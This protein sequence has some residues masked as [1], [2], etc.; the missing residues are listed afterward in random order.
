MR[1]RC[2]R[3]VGPTVGEG[4]YVRTCCGVRRCT[5]RVHR[6]A[7][8]GRNFVLSRCP[9]HLGVGALDGGRVGASSGRCRTLARRRLLP[10]RLDKRGPSNLAGSD[11][12]DDISGKSLLQE[13]PLQ[14]LQLREIPRGGRD[15]GSIH[16]AAGDEPFC[17]GSSCRRVINPQFLQE[18]PRVALRGSEDHA[19]QLWAQCSVG[20]R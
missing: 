8:N 17:A 3:G 5:T 7:F 1:A 2:L 11:C 18:L 12:C 6:S 19:M 16:G 4:N 15:M 9:M 20:G 14:S 10:L 13:A